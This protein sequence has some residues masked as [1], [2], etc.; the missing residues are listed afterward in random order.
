MSFH[1]LIQYGQQ[2]VDEGKANPQWHLIR[3]PAFLATIQNNEIVN[4]TANDIK[5]YSAMSQV[6]AMSKSSNVAPDLYINPLSYLNPLGKSKSAVKRYSA[7]V[8]QL[9]DFNKFSPSKSLESLIKWHDT[10]CAGFSILLEEIAKKNKVEVDDL[11]AYMKGS[12]AFPEKEIKKLKA[13][14]STDSIEFMVDGEM[15][16]TSKNVCMSWS[17]F[18]QSSTDEEDSVIITDPFTGERGERCNIHRVFPG[19]MSRLASYDNSTVEQTTLYLTKQ[20][21]NNIYTALQH[22]YSSTTNSRRVGGLYMYFFPKAGNKVIPVDVSFFGDLGN[23]VTNEEIPV[24]KMIDVLKGNLKHYEDIGTKLIVIV[25]NI[26][27]GRVSIRRS[28]SSKDFL[29]SIET[30]VQNTSGNLIYWDKSTKSYQ[31]KN[32]PPTINKFMS[33]LNTLCEGSS[34]TRDRAVTDIIDSII[35]NNKIPISFCDQIASNIMRLSR[36]MKLLKPADYSIR[37]AYW[38][39]DSIYKNNKGATAMDELENNV[40]F[41]LGKWFAIQCNIVYL[42][43]GNEDPV[44]KLQDSLIRNPK[45]A[46]HRVIMKTDPHIK[47]LRRDMP[48]AATNRWKESMAVMDKITSLGGLPEK[49]SYEFHLGYSSKVVEYLKAS[50][51]AKN[52]K[53]SKSS[54]NNDDV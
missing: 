32:T 42:A 53:I 27:Q 12:E 26:K 47:T 19:S 21:E 29:S 17:A 43:F 13:A 54:S 34:A 37:D 52:K 15:M 38:A 50:E 51:D 6:S 8:S 18:M 14:T 36:K 7:M 49:M 16:H 45:D 30:Y 25:F 46:L 1:D 33:V 35:N 20:T 5:T 2:L 28:W 48:G 22:M 4:V 41:L 44:H 11:V 40:S 9:K 10:G 23:T 39:L 24:A 31:V 3:K